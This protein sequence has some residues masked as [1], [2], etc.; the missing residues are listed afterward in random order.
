MQRPEPVLRRLLGGSPAWLLAT[1]LLL[2]ASWLAGIGLLALSGWFITASALA[3]AGL[4]LGLDIFLPS[5]G[6][7]AA[8]LLR[9]LARYGERVVGHETVLRRLA[10]LRRDTF[11]A[12]ARLPLAAR[13]AL[14]SGDWQGRLGA[15]ID[16]LDALPLR[17]LAPA[18]A[19]ALSVLAAAGL[20]TALGAVAIA[21]L[22]LGLGLLI[23]LGTGVAVRAGL[24]HGEALVAGRHAERV[25]LLDHLGGQAELRAFGALARSREA[26]AAC[27]RDQSGQ[28]AR[29]QGRAALF[30][31]LAQ[32]AVWLASLGTLWLSLS[33]CLAAAWSGPVAVLLPLMVL[34]LGEALSALPG[35]GWRLGESIAAARR[36]DAVE[37]GGPAVLPAP[38]AVA[39]SSDAPGLV[40]R[41]LRIGFDARRALLPALDLAVQPGRPLV[42]V[43]ASGTGKSVLLETL[44]GERPALGGGAWLDGCPVEALDADAVALLPQETVLLDASIAANL[45]LARPDVP[46][47]AAGALLRGL[48][49]DA[50]APDG[51]RGWRLRVGEA[52][53]NL[54]GGEAR[55][56]LLAWL[57][58]RQP[59]LALLDEPFAGLDADT[60]ATVLATMSP[61]LAGR[62]CM[63]ATHEPGRL[64][65]DWPR[66]R[67]D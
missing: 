65:P 11:A 22:V 36:L 58:L 24:A 6:I 51:R 8:A 56:L 50:F 29:Q 44:A 55:R 23:G 2:A 3:G 38:R 19:A 43:A 9:T 20:A 35:A 14:R 33:G 16:A 30:T 45:R 25:A 48:G 47:E 41:G 26:L 39:A 53:G 12:I 10:E 5:A 4:L 31:Q 17:V 46:P 32:L 52:A 49:L 66:L 63:I 1:T 64:P 15:D 61:W 21:G 34:G 18:A 13:R 62:C 40:V 42:L 60:T 37:A 57:L 59:R 54:S 67:L 28:L 27:E 7:R